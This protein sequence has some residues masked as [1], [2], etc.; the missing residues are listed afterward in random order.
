MEFVRGGGLCEI[1]LRRYGVGKGFCAE[2]HTRALL[3]PL[4]GSPLPE[5]AYGVASLP[6]VGNGVR[7]RR[8]RL[9]G[10]AGGANC[11]RSTQC[12]HPTEGEWSLYADGNSHA[13][14]PSVPIRRAGRSA[15]DRIQVLLHALRGEKS[16]IGGIGNPSEAPHLHRKSLRE[17]RLAFFLDGRWSGSALTLAAEAV[18]LQGCYTDVHVSVFFL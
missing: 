13:Q 9:C 6:K 5:G 1:G 14:A 16:P 11:L 2:F 8:G 3:H 10:I 4:R 7:A 17:V 18:N 12:P 15:R